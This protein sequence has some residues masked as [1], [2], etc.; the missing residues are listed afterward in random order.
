MDSRLNAL[1]I[2]ES[3]LY[4]SL[5]TLWLCTSVSVTC[6]YIEFHVVLL[7]IYV[8]VTMFVTHF[9]ITVAHQILVTNIRCHDFSALADWFPKLTMSSTPM[10]TRSVGYT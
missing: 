3:G 10:H 8:M 7:R 5:L 6:K 1:C 9:A 2:P 4:L